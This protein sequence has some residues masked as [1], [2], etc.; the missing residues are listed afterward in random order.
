MSV[1]DIEKYYA[2]CAEPHSSN[3]LI[4]KLKSGYCAIERNNFL[5]R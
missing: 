3:E 1:G 5:L 4:V 2:L